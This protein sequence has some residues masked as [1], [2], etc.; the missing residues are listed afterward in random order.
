MTTPDQTTRDWL[1]PFLGSELVRVNPG[2]HLCS[3]PVAIDLDDVHDELAERI[4]VALLALPPCQCAQRTVVFKPEGPWPTDGRL[5]DEMRMVA[6]HPDE[7]CPLIPE[8][9]LRFAAAGCRRGVRRVLRTEFA[10]AFRIR[11]VGAER[12][13]GGGGAW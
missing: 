4:S 11:P 10:R 5:G 7:A 9:R 1:V 6:I 3:F 13:F 12:L 8:A 2:I